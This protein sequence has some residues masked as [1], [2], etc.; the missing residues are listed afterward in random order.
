MQWVFSSHIFSQKKWFFAVSF[1]HKK[2]ECN[3]IT[4]TMSNEKTCNDLLPADPE[5]QKMGREILAASPFGKSQQHDISERFS[6]L[7][8]NTISVTLPGHSCKVCLLGTLNSLLIFWTAN[9]INKLLSNYA[10]VY[11]HTGLYWTQSFCEQK[12]KIF[13]EVIVSDGQIIEGRKRRKIN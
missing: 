11:K 2:W 7:M 4:S 12:M 13:R 1:Q 8:C 3:N 6:K 5:L 10:N 9:T